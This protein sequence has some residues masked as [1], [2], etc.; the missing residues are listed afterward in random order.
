VSAE[1]HRVDA[2]SG[3]V[4][5][6]VVVISSTRTLETDV[7]GKAI[8]AAL[9]EAGH[10]VQQ[11]VV[12]PDDAAQIRAAV[13]DLVKDGHELLVLTGGTGPTP[14]DVTPEAIEPLLTRRLDGFGELFR[15]L[16]Y[17]Q[18]GAAA[19][20]SRAVGG[21]IGGAV[22]FALPGSSKACA[23]ALEALILPEV[24]HLVHLAR[25]SGVDAVPTVKVEHHAG[26]R[27]AVS[28]LGGE[29]H[30][31]RRDEVPQAIEKL[32][33]VRSVLD[34]AG[35]VGVLTLPGGQS[36]TLWGFP[37]LRR[38]SSKVLAVGWGSPLAEVL[39]LHRHPVHTGTCI[40]EGHGLLAGR[41]EVAK[42][43]VERT[44]RPP[45]DVAGAVFAVAGE[46][47]YIERGGAVACWDGAKER[48]LGTA[49]Q[50]LATLVL[51]WSSR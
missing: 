39:A 45:A 16:S 6:A 41:S 38:D 18:V 31:D 49:K 8:A 19:M 5:A 21:L 2:G 13:T 4:V 36:Y 17:Q 3:G 7:S 28:D 12:V 44:G 9:H 23:L 32:A 40:D 51:E 10:D 29:V 15:S 33:S 35:E 1:E 27:R 37:D 34:T 20:L 30:L 48:D 47:V 25:P 50:A 46:A 22:I 11:R 42:V 14:S 24:R 43:A 26:W